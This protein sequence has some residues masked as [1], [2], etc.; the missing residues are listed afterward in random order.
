MEER[1]GSGECVGVEVEWEE[2]GVKGEEKRW[3]GSWEREWK[4]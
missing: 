2:E 4:G 3:E 1:G